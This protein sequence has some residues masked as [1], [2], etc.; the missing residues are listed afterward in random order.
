MAE[1]TGLAWRGPK[2]LDD[3]VVNVRL[4]VRYLWSLEERFDDPHLAIA[5]YNLGPT[6][7]ARMPRQRAQ[8]AQYVQRVLARY[9]DLVEQYS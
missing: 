9:D 1:E 5:A 3:G 6:R 4:G 7:V 8:R 2:T